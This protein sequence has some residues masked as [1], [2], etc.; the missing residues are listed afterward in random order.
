MSDKIIGTE[1]NEVLLGTDGDDIII[2]L[3]GYDTLDGGEGSD[4][5]IVN[6]DD[7]NDRFVDFYN[8]SGL[9]GTDTI[10]ASEAGIDIGIGSGFSPDSGI[11]AIDGLADSRIVGDNDAQLWDFSETAITGVSGI[12]GNGG[13]DEIIGTTLADNIDGGSGSDTLLGNAGDDALSGGFDSDFIYGGN[14]QDTI[15]GDEGHDTIEGGNGRDTIFGG[16]GHDTIDGGSDGDFIFGGEGHD[17]IIGGEGND[18]ITGGSG[19]DILDGGEGS[20]TYFVGLENEGFVDTYQDSGTVGTDRI[21]ASEDATI[22][23][24]INGFGPDSGIEVIGASGNQDVTIGGTN[25]SETWDFSQTQLN[26]IDWINALDGHDVVTGNDQNNRIDA[27]AGHDIVNGGAGND[28]LVGNDGHDTLNGGEGRDRL[29]GGAGFDTLDGGEGDD[30][31]LYSTDSN[32][33]IDTIQDTGSSLKDRLVATEDNVEFRLQS[34]FSAQNGIEIITARRNDNV[35]I[36]GSDEGVNWD[37]TDVILRGI[38]EING[39]E[40]RDIIHGSSR[41]NTINGGAGPDQLYGGKGRDTL[42]GGE[43]SDFLFGELGRD[44]LFGGAGNDV[45]NGGK[46]RDFLTGGAGF[47]MFE[48]E[49][50]AGHD[51]ITDFEVS[52]DLIDLSSFDGELSFEDLSF[53]STD[54]GVR[55]FFEGSSVVLE[56]VEM[57][58][59]TEDM[60]IF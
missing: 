24:L 46:G 52:A 58:A 32:G 37:F 50:G 44:N 43:D 16:V 39:G 23:G 54:S 49:A 31:Y 6:A 51:V 9:T 14:G 38:S 25:D 40:A 20:D 60:F 47:D 34:D 19:F 28:R 45:L 7:F 26:G 42:N 1:R 30:V 48:F 4:T 15:H 18:Q 3:S 22:I 29:E 35:T 12:F 27:G 11:E 41:D 56:N 8:D 53:R 2:G 21:L 59:I 55:V 36:G 33:W 10:L 13:R 17:T 57:D 5:Y